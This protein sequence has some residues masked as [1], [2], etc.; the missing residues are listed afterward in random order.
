MRK[1]KKEYSN[2]EITVSWEPHL[3]THVGICFTELNEVFEP[4]ASP[5]IDMTGAPTD[6]IVEVVRMCPTGALKVRFN[7]QEKQMDEMETKS[8]VK[9]KVL[10]NGPILVEG[11]FVITGADGKELPKTGKAAI[12]RC[13][14]SSKKPFCDG[15]HV[16]AGF[17]D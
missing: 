11:D 10:P 2:G 15:S 8:T 9:M 7:N 16:K 5:W 4:M 14:H 17:K 13:G 1:L 12:C 3:C 6:R